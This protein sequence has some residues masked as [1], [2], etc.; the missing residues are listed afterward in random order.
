MIPMINLHKQFESI[1]GEVMEAV[2]AVLESSAYVLGPRVREFEEKVREYVGAGSA[3]GVASGTDALHLA[4]QALGVKRG[5]EV[6][7][8]PFTFF[9]TVEAICYLGARPVLVDIEHDTMNI[10]PEKIEARITKKTKAILPVHIF[11]HPAE[12]GRIMDIAK[13]HSLLVVEDCAQSFGATAKGLM[14]GGI[15][16]A[17]CYS[18]YPSKNLGAVGD[19]GL[20]TLKDPAVADV[21]R[22]L[23]NHGSSKTYRHDVIGINS[24]LDEIQ[25]AI[26]LV[27]FKH[28]EQ[29]NE[30]RR[31]KAALYRSLLGDSV[32]CPIERPGYRHVYHQFTVRSP[33]RDALQQALKAEGIS[34]MIYYPVPLHLQKALRKLGYKKGDLPEAERAASEV[35]SLP[36]CPELNPSDIELISSVIR[37]A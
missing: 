2:A 17:G 12:M 7:T 25:A 20:V 18:F 15:G 13:R 32:E 31:Q 30:L 1:R 22:M 21:V 6:I 27:K 36:I 34:S 19:G 35:L 9:A 4:L 5:D 29:W 8:T 10:D 37:R 28:I 14:T 11:G 26:L 3:L 24:R 16:D 23:R 33:R